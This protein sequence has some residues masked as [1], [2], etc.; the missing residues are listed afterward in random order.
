MWIF[1]IL[2]LLL[3]SPSHHSFYFFPFLIFASSFSYESRF[4]CFVC[5]RK[6]GLLRKTFTWEC[7]AVEG[8]R[9]KHLTRFTADNAKCNA[10]NTT[11][12]GAKHT[13]KKQQAKNKMNLLK[14]AETQFK[15][16]RRLFGF[17]SLSSTKDFAVYIIHFYCYK[18]SVM[19]VL[20]VCAE[21]LS[22]EIHA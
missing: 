16:F 2:F 7:V 11:E 13:N 9:E 6:I 15:N 17:Q 14:A 19:I 8:G 18:F 10:V 1:F 20:C 5:N 4:C 12:T 3:P 22:G 21:W